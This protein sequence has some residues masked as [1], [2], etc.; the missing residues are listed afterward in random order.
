MIERSPRAEY[1][2]QGDCLHAEVEP[3]NGRNQ[4]T[5]CDQSWRSLGEWHYARDEALKGTK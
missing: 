5:G 2:A 1:N 3:R 4:C